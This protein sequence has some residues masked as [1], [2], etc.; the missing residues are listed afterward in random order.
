MVWTNIV[1]PLLISL[2]VS[3]LYVHLWRR[4]IRRELETDAII[5]K[6][7]T[8][9]DQMVTELN[10]TTERNIALLEDRI[11]QTNEL[12]EKAAKAAGVLKRESEKQDF[13]NQV[14]TS[15]GKSRPLNLTVDDENEVPERSVVEEPVDFESLSVREKALVL[16]RRG[17]NADSIASELNMSRGEVELMISLHDRRR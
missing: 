14:Y 5:G 11:R 16:H 9:V 6:L 7:R 4:R 8:E 17:Q 2:G 3:A 1:F 15:L 10:G 12:V 13:S